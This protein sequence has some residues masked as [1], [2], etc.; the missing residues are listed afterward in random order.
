MRCKRFKKNKHNKNISLR[1]FAICPRKWHCRVYQVFKP[2]S[3][4]LCV[5][6]ICFFLSQRRRRRPFSTETRLCLINLAGRMEQ[7]A[8]TNQINQV[9][10]TDSESPT[11]AEYTPQ[12]DV[13]CGCIWVLDLERHDVLD[14][15][16]WSCQ[17][18][19]FIK[20]E[21]NEKAHEILI[22]AG[23]YITVIQCLKTY[24]RP[25]IEKMTGSLFRGGIQHREATA[26]RTGEGENY[27]RNNL[28]WK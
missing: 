21:A 24:K 23:A 20:Q 4:H 17:M 15:I 3:L 8:V 5:T 22:K 6:A 2:I 26:C 7:Q 28:S 16:G 10:V 27:P 1:S 18:V 11:K 13:L 25:E 19:A 12:A 9:R 14:L